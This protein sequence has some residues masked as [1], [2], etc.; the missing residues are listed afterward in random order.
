MDPFGGNHY[1]PQSLHKYSYA[2]GDPVNGID[3]SGEFTLIELLVVIGIIGI[4]AAVL[5]PTFCAARDNIRYGPR[6]NRSEI[7][8]SVDI[9]DLDFDMARSILQTR[10]GIPVNIFK[11]EPPS[12]LPEN[13]RIITLWDATIAGRGYAETGPVSRVSR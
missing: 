2:H 7:Y 13:I 10:L 6:Y 4:L 5:L 12:D 8:N 3:P 11:G 9:K 1:D